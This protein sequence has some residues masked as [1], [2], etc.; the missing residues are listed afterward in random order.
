M[1]IEMLGPPGVGKTTLALALTDRLRKRGV[2]AELAISYRPAEQLVSAAARSGVVSAMHRI[3]RPGWELIS[4]SL[5]LSGDSAEATSRFLLHALPPRSL[6]WRVRLRQYIWRFAHVWYAARD[7]ERVWI[8]DQAFMQVIGSLVLLGR[9]TDDACIAG[10]LTRVPQP[11]L[12]ICLDA[13]REVL[14][15]RLVERQSRQRWLERRF[16]LDLDS[17]LKFAAVLDRVLALARQQGAVPISITSDRSQ[18]LAPALE[19]LEQKVLAR[20]SALRQA[21]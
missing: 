2:G 20:H 18:S 7:D 3:M 4:H 1:I 15:A 13:P 16:E 6:L 11:D 12:L 14:R 10:M 5:H 19:L 21:A 17:N 9:P 8:F